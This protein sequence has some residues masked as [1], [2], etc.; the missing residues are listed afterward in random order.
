MDEKLESLGLTKEEFDEGYDPADKEWMMKTLTHPPTA[1]QLAI[2]MG[3]MIKRPEVQG[4]SDED[5]N[6]IQYS[7]LCSLHHM[8]KDL[9]SVQP[10][11]GDMVLQLTKTDE[12]TFEPICINVIKNRCTRPTVI[13]RH[14]YSFPT[15]IEV[16]KVKEDVPKHKIIDVIKK[17]IDQI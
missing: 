6:A 10:M 12:E 3:K 16:D 8:W 11:P 13:Q 1:A 4:W 17:N 14:G 9:A 2:T 5:D 7:A 15:V